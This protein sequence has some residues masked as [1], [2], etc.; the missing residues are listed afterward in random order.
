MQLVCVISG[1]PWCPLLSRSSCDNLQHQLL[2]VGRRITL[3][4]FRL[5]A[6]SSICATPQ[7]TL[8]IWRAGRGYCSKNGTMVF[9]QCLCLRSHRGL[10]TIPIKNLW[11][12]APAASLV[13]EK[14]PTGR[15]S[16]LVLLVAARTAIS[17][18]ASRSSYLN[19]LRVYKL[20]VFYPLIG[21]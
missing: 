7:I 2:V 20:G 9:V 13:S 11:I 8:C 6:F 4:I 10:T 19:L 18:K 12:S 1:S 16:V 21:F 3:Q 5:R 15:C 17:E 14:N